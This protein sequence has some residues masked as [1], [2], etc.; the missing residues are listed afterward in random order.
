[1]HV[2]GDIFLVTLACAYMNVSRAKIT[3]KLTLA[4]CFLLYVAGIEECKSDTFH[5]TDCYVFY[6][7]V[8]LCVIGKVSN[9]F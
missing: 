3:L 9:Y 8:A 6:D 4:L 5:I 2:S 7:V 1:M